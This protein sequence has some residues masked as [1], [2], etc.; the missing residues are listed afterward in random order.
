MLN[1]TESWVEANGL[2]HH[3][4]CWNDAGA[5]TIVLCHGFLDLA[6][7]FQ[8]LAE[9]LA[10]AG[11]RVV[12]FD[13][14]GHGESARIGAGGYY[15]FPDYV[16]DL[17]ELLPKLAPD[18]PHLLGHSMGGTAV[19][20]YAGTHPGRVRSVVLVEGL[21]P[22][23]YGGTAPEKMVTWLE[24]VNR[25]RGRAPRQIRDLDEAVRRLR[26]QTPELPES[27]ARFIAEKA[28]E[29][30]KDGSLRWRFDPLHRTTS[31][32]PFAPRTFLEFLER[33]EAPTLVVS[34][35]HGFRTVDHERRAAALRSAREVVIPNVGHMVHWLTPDALAEAVLAHTRAL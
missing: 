7:S 33:I 22:P 29:P 31:P 24:S 15:H 10:S 18:K 11:L 12:A 21:G 34:G 9:R 14:R 16:L 35:E 27:L 2:E 1:P 23:A 26:V 13:W 3:V 8:P 25:L 20:L 4:L 28:T 32:T 30:N 6:W 17:H 5:E 19:A